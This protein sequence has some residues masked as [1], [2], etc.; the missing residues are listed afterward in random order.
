MTP[1][2]AR[3]TLRSASESRCTVHLQSRASRWVEIHSPC[4]ASAPATCRRSP[5]AR[6][7]L[8]TVPNSGLPLADNALYRL[9]LANPRLLRHDRH[10]SG[11][12]D[13]P[14]RR[15]NEVHVTIFE[16]GVQVGDHVL[17][18]LEMLCRIPR[19]GARLRHRRCLLQPPR[20][21]QR[22]SYVP[23]LA[24]LVAAGQ[25][26]SA[27]ATSVHPA[28]PAPDPVIVPPV[29]L[30]RCYHPRPSSRAAR[31]ERE[32]NEVRVSSSSSRRTAR[33]SGRAGVAPIPTR[34][35]PSRLPSTSAASRVSPRRSA[36]TSSPSRSTSCC[37]STTSRATRT[38]ST[39]AATSSATPTT[40]RR[41]PSRSPRSPSSP[42][43]PSA[44]SSAPRC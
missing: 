4:A 40:R 29:P 3:I 21:L 14:Q 7:T 41:S 43:S 20:Q 13:V 39:R 8:S 2:R 24:A 30:R 5:R 44:S 34:V 23:V 17:F 11:T 19:S 18:R 33:T 38:S 27:Q 16:G 25:K 9:S 10:S 37:P 22:S 12:G 6:R 28:I 15:H 35:R 36:S 31:R 32:A 1:A 42:P 26:R